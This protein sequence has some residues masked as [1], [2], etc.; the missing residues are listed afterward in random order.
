MVRRRGDVELD[1]R[2]RAIV[3]TSGKNKPTPDTSAEERYHA[4]SLRIRNR[5]AE[6]LTLNEGTTWATMTEINN[7]AANYA[8]CSSVTA[9]RWVS[10]FTVVGTAHKIILATDYFLIER[11][12]EENGGEAKAET[13]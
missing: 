10:Q 2:L 3:E 8:G 9:A 12:G 1:P 13:S 11:R 5:I 7:R 6:W 4:R